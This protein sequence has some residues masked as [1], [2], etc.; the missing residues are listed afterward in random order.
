MMNETAEM[1]NLRR[2]L[3]AREPS[4]TDLGKFDPNDSDAYKDA[5]LNLLAQ[6]FGVLK[7]PLCY[8][9]RPDMPPATFT[10]NEE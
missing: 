7:E 10:T 4:I 2:E 6:T 5:F 8:A 1:K 9:V 3:A